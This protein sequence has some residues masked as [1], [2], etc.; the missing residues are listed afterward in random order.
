MPNVD[1]NT[2][3]G[4][5]L[6]EPK[7]VA[8]AN[9]NQTYV[10]DGLGSGAWSEP[11]PKDVS[12]ATAAQVYVADGSSSGAWTGLQMTVSGVIA[13]VSTAET[14]YF[15]VPYAC[16]VTRVTTVLEGAITAAD[17]TLTLRNAAG[18][19]MA[20]IT[21]ANAGSAAGDVDSADPGSNNTIAANSFFTIETNG[22]STGA[23]RVWVTAYL[24]RS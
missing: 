16:S 1:H 23:Q 3:V 22:S 7:G 12:S 6:H 4:A 13:D 8:A 2:L 14:I 11:E 21:V 20:T 17:A 9:A 10:A 15:P 24:T 5:E 18:T 19:A